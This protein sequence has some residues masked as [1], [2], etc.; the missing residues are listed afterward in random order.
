MIGEERIVACVL[1][2]IVEG[3][4]LDLQFLGLFH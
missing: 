3:A 2:K 4:S 1:V